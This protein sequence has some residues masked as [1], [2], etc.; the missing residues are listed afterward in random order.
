VEDRAQHRPEGDALDGEDLPFIA[1]ELVSESYLPRLVPAKRARR[2]MI[3][4]SQ[5][6]AN[7][8]LSLLMANQH[9]W[10]LLNREGFTATWDGSPHANGITVEYDTASRQH[11][12]AAESRFGYGIL[13]WP[14]PYLF[15]TPPGW[16]L[17]TKGPVN[18]PKDG[19][20]PLEGLIESDWAEVTFTMNWKFTRPDHPVRFEPD[21]PFAMLVP[22]RRGALE[23]LQPERRPIT[24]A[25][26]T[27]ARMQSWA[28]KR[29]EEE[30]RAFL[31]K[32]FPESR[33][34]PDWDG[35]YM[36][37]SRTDQSPFDG[38]QRVMDLKPFQRADEG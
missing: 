7:R 12:S 4:T 9:G 14:V 20:A 33:G 13:S 19:I 25:P 27:L 29:Q 35:R 38:H 24:D 32:Y 18:M 10:W 22:H 23:A 11:K 30:K 8:C 34:M 16:N 6:F 15:R 5:S 36:R 3:E 28:L 2:W 26:E 37:G 1:Y 21:E 17:I 31:G